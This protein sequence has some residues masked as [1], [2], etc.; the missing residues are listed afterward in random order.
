MSAVKSEPTLFSVKT[1]AGSD[2]E[3]SLAPATSHNSA[4]T[5]LSW[6]SGAST[7]FFSVQVSR[8]KAQTKQKNYY[9]S[10]LTNFSQGPAA[11]AVRFPATKLRRQPGDSADPAASAAHHCSPGPD[12]G[13]RANR[14]TNRGCLITIKFVYSFLSQVLLLLKPFNFI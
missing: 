4:P 6:P 10:Q 7:P 1:E 5:L 3:V 2:V 14:R 11:S 13:D 8:E 12:S 9:S